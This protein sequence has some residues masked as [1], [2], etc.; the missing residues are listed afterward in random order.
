MQKTTTFAAGV[1]AIALVPAAA[2]AQKPPKDPKPPPKPPA[3]APALT[4]DAAPNPLVFGTPVKLAGKLSNTASDRGVVVRLEQDQTRPFGDS[5]KSTGLTATT[6]NNGSYGF[7]FKPAKNTQYR[8]VAQASPPVTSNPRLVLVRP[9]V[10]L[11]VSTQRPVAGRLVRFFGIV[12][13]ARSG[14]TAIVQK[15]TSRGFVTVAR[16]RLSGS[17]GS[18]SIRARVRSAGDYRVKVPGNAEFVNGLSRLV[19]ITTR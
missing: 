15:R 12:R 11:R 14:G 6:E 3:G 7:A 5:Y 18:Y 9:L 8:A 10:G 2:L 17:G 19:R 16:R 4:L 13:P 1:L